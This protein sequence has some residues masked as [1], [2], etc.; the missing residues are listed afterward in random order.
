MVPSLEQITVVFVELAP[1]LKPCCRNSSV[2]TCVTSTFFFSFSFFKPFG[3]LVLRPFAPFRG[4]KRGA[5]SGMGS[6][7]STDGKSVPYVAYL[8]KTG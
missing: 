5:G 2:S 8:G 3:F 6:P 4:L 7:G 1:T